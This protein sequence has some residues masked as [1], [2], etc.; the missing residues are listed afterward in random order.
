LGCI[1][2]STLGIAP[3]T[4]DIEDGEYEDSVALAVIIVIPLFEMQ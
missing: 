4:I 3:I 2:S 1:R